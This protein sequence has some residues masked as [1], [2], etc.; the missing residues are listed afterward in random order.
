MKH[1]G[2]VYT[3][4]LLKGIKLLDYSSNI[5]PIS[6]SLDF[7]SHINEALDKINL[8]PD[9]KYRTLKKDLITYLKNS[10]LYFSKNNSNSVYLNEITEKNIFVGNGASEVLDLVISS[11]NSITIVVPSF[12]E[13]EDFSKKH[14]LKVEYSYLDN[15]MEYDYNDIITK[16]SSTDGLIIGNPNNPNGCIID[17]NNFIKIL[18]YCEAQQKLVIID[19]AFI[20]FVLDYDKS[21]IKYIDKYNSIVIIRAITKFY[22]MPG[23]RFGYG[24]ARN[25]KLID[26]IEKKQNP[27]SVNCFAEIAVKYALADEDFIK[28]SKEWIQ[29]ERDLMFFSLNRISFIEKVYR[30]YGNYFLCKLKDLNSSELY[31]IMLS[32]G[33]L[34]RNCSNYLGLN[35]FYVRF[36]IKDSKSNKI[37][38]EKLKIVE[39]CMIT[40]NKQKNC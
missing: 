13:Y 32:N 5:N 30:S 36:A 9:V 17:F 38:I 19:E 23:I 14:K 28:K 10:E 25:N 4:G 2:D 18:N 3:E 12:V 15:E 35:N 40:K 31:E 29:Q 22:G 27:W 7:T 20:E 33:I 37:F 34:I 24:I 11:L 1:G 39:S 21:I 8:Y 26:F 6:I 16:L